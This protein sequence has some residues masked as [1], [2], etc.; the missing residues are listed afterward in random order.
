MPEMSE[1]VRTLKETTFIG[2]NRNKR[3]DLNGAKIPLLR[4]GDFED[5]EEIESI[6]IFSMRRL[7]KILN[8]VKGGDAH[9]V[10]AIPSNPGDIHES[11]RGDVRAGNRAMCNH[12]LGTAIFGNQRASVLLSDFNGDTDP[13]TFVRLPEVS[14]PPREGTFYPYCYCFECGQNVEGYAEKARETIGA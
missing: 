8:S 4:K 2:T 6:L 7:N 10:P 12:A 11:W 9:E 13:W 5:L 1:K 14:E 3:F